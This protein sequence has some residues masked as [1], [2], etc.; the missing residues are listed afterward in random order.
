[1]NTKAF[2]LLRLLADA[3]FHSGEALSNLLDVSRA[4]VWN[5]VH[6][7]REAGI[8]VF[9]VTGRGYK[10]SM[11]I[12]MFEVER[13]AQG[14]GSSVGKLQLELVNGIESTN[15][16]LMLRAADPVKA[17]A[18]HGICLIAELQTRGRGRRGRS[19]LAGIGGGVTFSLLWRFEQGAAHLSALSLA[20]G[21]AL[22][23]ALEELGVEHAKLKWP[24]D[25]IHHHHKLAGVL[26]ELE[27]DVLGP[28][29]A[30][31][32]VGINVRLAEAL[33]ANIDQAVTDL[34]TLTGAFVD[35]NVALACVLRHLVAVLESYAEEGFAPFK[36]SWLARHAYEGREVW[37]QLPKGERQT[38]R[39]TGVA[40]DGSLLLI[41]EQGQK[42]YTV[43]EISVRATAQPK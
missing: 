37:L 20:V 36:E 14:L 1:M 28:S 25:V 32:G 33:R 41:T 42:R 43:G 38:G 18:L 5:L 16:A 11:P 19:W 26:I 10:L 29:T 22:V 30:V 2:K 8:E 6:E 35:R 4:T 3:E 31:I 13:I 27:G 23:R 34:E 15:S 7:L 12:S 24:N 39:V 40:D 17:E 9:S 21:L